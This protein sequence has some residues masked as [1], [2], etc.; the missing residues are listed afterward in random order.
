M[1]GASSTTTASDQPGQA[2]A[3]RTQDLRDVGGEHS[4][5]LPWPAARQVPR[6]QNDPTEGAV[7]RASPANY[8]VVRD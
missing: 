6:G 3:E 8:D 7:R 1:A 4:Q 2:Q 5:S